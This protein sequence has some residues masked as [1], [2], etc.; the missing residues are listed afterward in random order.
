MRRGS[1]K[2]FYIWDTGKGLEIEM[3]YVPPG[4]FIMGG[5]DGDPDEVPR[6][7]HPMPRGYWLGRF[8]TRWKEFRVFCQSQHRPDP[9]KPRFG[10]LDEHPVVNVT[11]HDAA[12]FCSWAG[13]S[14]PSEAEW[15]KAAR[16]SDGRR[17]PW[18]HDWSATLANFCD[19][20]CPDNII[21]KDKSAKDGFPYTAPVGSFPRGASPVGALD[22]A[23]NAWE[24]CQ[25]WYDEGA[26]SRYAKG[27]LEPPRHGATK[28]KRGGS[29][30]NSA[31]TCRSANR[32]DQAPDVRDPATGLRPVKRP[33]E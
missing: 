5:E 31:P 30:S 13:L 8:E 2:P 11:W 27:K 25:D 17:Y 33:E 12:A 22:M 15:E 4:D 9:P 16:G 20:T 29:W 19:A 18:G 23:G 28:V 3:V 1:A 21:G 10:A 6:H 26:Y 24:W 7:T 32:H 14:L